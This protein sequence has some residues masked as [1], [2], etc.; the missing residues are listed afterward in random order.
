MEFF[1]DPEFIKLSALGC[2]FVV[3]VSVCIYVALRE[4]AELNR[5][6]RAKKLIYQ[7][8]VQR[9]LNRKKHLMAKIQTQDA[10]DG[11]STQIQDQ[12]QSQTTMQRSGN[13]S[14]A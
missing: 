11:G 2:A 13:Q 6:R 5:R 10:D 7:D 12:I 4:T 3:G 14:F 9:E 1:A 8:Q